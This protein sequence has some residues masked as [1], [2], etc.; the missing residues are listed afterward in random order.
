MAT[1]QDRINILQAYYKLEQ[2][3]KYVVAE[4]RGDVWTDKSFKVIQIL[5]IEPKYSKGVTIQLHP[6]RDS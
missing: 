5:V 3:A 4:G 2:K 1:L 6:P